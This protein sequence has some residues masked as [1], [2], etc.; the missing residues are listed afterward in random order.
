M[1]RL[2]IDGVHLVRRD[3]L[4]L[5]GERWLKELQLA[6][7]RVEILDGIAAARAGDIN[8]MHEH[9]RA[10]QMAQKPV[11][12]PLPA[13]RAFDEPGHV[14]DGEAAVAA[15][16][17]DAQIRRQ[18]GER[19]I[20]DLGTCGGDAGDER[21]LAGIGEADQTDVGEQLQFEP[22]VFDLA[23]LAWLDLPR[24]AIGRCGEPGVAH[25]PASAVCNEHALTFFGE[26]RKEPVRLAGI[27]SLLVHE[28]P[29]RYRQLEIGAS[30]SRA[31]RA[32]P[33]IATLGGELR[34][35]T[36][37]DERVGMRARD[38]EDR[39]AVAAVAAARPAARHELLAPERQA[40]AAAVARGDVNVDLVDE[41]RKLGDLVTWKSGKWIE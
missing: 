20:G 18:R 31:V 19:I 27:A 10:F 41:H 7:D 15:Q 35:E 40:P 12:E 6:P 38:D 25:A 32:L 9:F 14:G 21:R 23:G 17:H 36:E 13:V 4:R 5:G 39:S 26:V 16:L 28:R 29:D 30:V 1:R 37:V 24:R 34:V 11:A 3:D 8:Q 2:V 33:V 22:K